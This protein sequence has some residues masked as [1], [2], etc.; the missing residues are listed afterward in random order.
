MDMDASTP[1]P[2]AAA[3]A[4]R[5]EVSLTRLYVLR[6]TYLLIVAPGLF[7]VL[8]RIIDPPDPTGRGMLVSM[9]SGL[10]VV[11][12]LGLR[13]PL[14]ML[15]IFLF[16]FVWK[17]LWLINYGLPQWMAGART[18]QLKEDMLLIGCGPLLW[19]LV[20]PWGY[21]WRHYIRKPADRWR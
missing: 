1:A 12:F 2:L 8:P 5:S 17:T 4:A 9:L 10:W 18:P 21:V 15:P 3:E 13:Y 16:E 7:S 14:Q 20:I 19:G 6:A 11:C